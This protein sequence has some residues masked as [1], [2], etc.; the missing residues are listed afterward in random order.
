MVASRGPGGGY[1]SQRPA[2]PTNNSTSGTISALTPAVPVPQ[3]RPQALQQQQQPA[4]SL[5]QQSSKFSQGPAVVAAA[6]A[7]APSS[8]TGGAYHH[9]GQYDS[10]DYDAYH[11]DIDGMY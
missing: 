9:R 4:V 11:R 6:P 2:E 10:H 7:V 8:G 5:R 3:P 1:Q